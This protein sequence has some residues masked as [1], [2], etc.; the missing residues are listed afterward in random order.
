MDG[1]WL[2]PFC[3]QERGDFAPHAAVVLCSI[4]QAA[5]QHAEYDIVV[6]NNKPLNFGLLL[7][8]KS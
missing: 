2:F 3:T 8:V 5:F 6:T 1:R 4:V 7:V